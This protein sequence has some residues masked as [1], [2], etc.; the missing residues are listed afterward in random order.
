MLK[1]GEKTEF[2]T[3][4]R[5][6]WQPTLSSKIGKETRLHS[7]GLDCR[8]ILNRTV[9]NRRKK[10]TKWHL[11]PSESSITSSIF[12]PF[13]IGKKPVWRL[14]RAVQIRCQNCALKKP[15]QEKANKTSGFF[16]EYRRN[17]EIV[18]KSISI[19]RFAWKRGVFR[20]FRISQQPPLRREVYLRAGPKIGNFGADGPYQYP[21]T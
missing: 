7:R 5:L 16:W 12:T 8:I 17:E 14:S 6:S 11:K 13:K 3:K 4:C 15:P 10:R 21:H 1:T 18:L 2:G 9:G 20:C 19:A